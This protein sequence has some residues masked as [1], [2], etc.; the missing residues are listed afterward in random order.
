MVIKNKKG[1]L[2]VIEATIAVLI[3][4]GALLLIASQ[5]E[6]KPPE[7]LSNLLPPILDEIAQDNDFRRDIVEIYDVSLSPDDD[8]NFQILENIEIFVGARISN[9]SLEYSASICDLNVVCPLNEEFPVQSN[10]DIFAAERAIS[11]TLEQ[12]EYNPRRLKIFLWK[13]P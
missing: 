13:K 6:T 7:D 4:L 9:P 8:T 1:F 2:R 3:V 5:K 10:K 11:A 12:V